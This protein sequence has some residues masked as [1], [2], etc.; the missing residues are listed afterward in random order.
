VDDVE[1]QPNHGWRHRFKQEARSI[2]MDVETRDAIQGH[3]ART[4]AQKYGSV[5][6][7]LMFEEISKL[8][9][10]NVS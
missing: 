9:R 2:R 6:V 7:K 10:Y 5:P 8:P 1:V 4:E 3:A